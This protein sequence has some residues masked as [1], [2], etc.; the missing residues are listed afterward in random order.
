[1]HTH[2]QYYRR[3]LQSF[4]TS[5]CPQPGE[6]EHHHHH[7]RTTNSTTHNTTKAE[8]FDCPR[9]KSLYSHQ[10]GR[11]VFLQSDNTVVFLAVML[12]ASLTGALLVCVHRQVL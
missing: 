9:L 1:M 11:S 6:P 4:Y 8:T 5:N 10:C 3:A 2:T 7:N 12:L